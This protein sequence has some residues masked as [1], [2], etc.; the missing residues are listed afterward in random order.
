LSQQHRRRSLKATVSLGGEGGFL[1]DE[2]GIAVIRPAKTKHG[3]VKIGAS[4][5]C[6]TCNSGGLRRDPTKILNHMHDVNDWLQN[7]D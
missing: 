1:I 5:N 2:K 6:A 7:S 3:R 4:A